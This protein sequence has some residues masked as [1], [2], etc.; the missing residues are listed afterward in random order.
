MYIR[1]SFRP[2][3][4]RRGIPFFYFVYLGT[5]IDTYIKEVECWSGFALSFFQDLFDASENEW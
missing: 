1:L 5:C 4:V 3:V 2:D